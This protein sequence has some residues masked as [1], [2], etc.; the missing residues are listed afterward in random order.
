[1]LMFYKI[2]TIVYEFIATYVFSIVEKKTF[3][4]K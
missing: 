3:H 4:E 2:V 1:M